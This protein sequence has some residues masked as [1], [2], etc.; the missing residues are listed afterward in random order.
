M[1]RW[2]ERGIKS[3]AHL[4]EASKL[5]LQLGAFGTRGGV[6]NAVAQDRHRDVA[7][8]HGILLVGRSKMGRDWG[9]RWG[10]SRTGRGAVMRGKAADHGRADGGGALALLVGGLVALEL[11]ERLRAHGLEDRE[12]AGEGDGGCQ[13]PDAAAALQSVHTT[14]HHVAVL[15]D[16][17]G[18]GLLLGD[19]ELLLER[20]A[21]EVGGIRVLHPVDRVHVAQVGLVR[22]VVVARCQEPGPGGGEMARRW[23]AGW[24]TSTYRTTSGSGRPPWWRRCSCRR[25]GC[26]G[27]WSRTRRPPCR[28]RASCTSCCRTC[29]RASGSACWPT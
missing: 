10:L 19:L 12:A 15:A 17:A 2:V 13:D 8:I 29:T 22:V 21:L 3:P 27:T 1:W 23:G 24:D 26:S 14:T 11:N 7:R 28:R 18:V 9:R 5:G 4:H 25:R 16:L 6:G 20:L